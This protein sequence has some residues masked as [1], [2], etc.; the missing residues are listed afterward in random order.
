MRKQKQIDYVKH[1]RNE[2]MKTYANH[3]DAWDAYD[4]HEILLGEEFLVH[5]DKHWF[6][7]T[8]RELFECPK[9]NHKEYKEESLLNGP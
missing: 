8:Q 3:F 9:C 5:G 7:K 4:K 2:K 6:S 1:K